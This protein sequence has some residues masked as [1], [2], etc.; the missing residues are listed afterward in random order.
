MHEISPLQVLL[1]LFTDADRAESIAGDLAEE[2]E[3]RGSLWFWLHGA[4]TAFGLFWNTL[5]S[6]PTSVLAVAALGFMLAGTLALGGVAAV[7][8]FPPIGSGTR[9]AL[10]SFYWWSTALWTG[11]SVASLAPR[12]G[13]TACLLLAA[14]IEL[15]LFSLPFFP[16]FNLA[17][18][19]PLYVS[20]LFSAIPLL[21]GGAIARSRTQSWCE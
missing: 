14:A 17:P 9:W 10:L 19:M 2:R 4:G 20:A 12:H 5:S 8:L 1:S 16:I 6:S 3:V 15:L 13:M 21:A 18:S 7:F 11:T